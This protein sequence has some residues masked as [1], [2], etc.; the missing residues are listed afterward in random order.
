MTQIKPFLSIVVPVRNEARFIAGTLEQLL[1]QDYPGDRF[2]IL[3]SDGLS[4]DGTVG[5]VREYAR[6]HPQVK[7]LVNEK[8]LSS[9]GR[10]LGFRKGRGDFFLV[11]DGHCHIE[12]KQLFRN[13]VRCFLENKADCLGRPQTLDP[14]GLTTFQKAVAAA[15]ASRLGR[16]G[17]SLIYSDF[18]GYA[19]P[20]SNGAAYGRNVFVKAGYVDE[21]F[22]ACED[23]EF[24]YRVEKAGLVCFSSPSLRVRYFPRENLRGLFRQMTRYGRGR[25]RFLK[26]HPDA[27]APETMI[28]ALFLA[29]MILPLLFGSVLLLFGDA[30][31]FLEAVFGATVLPY[32]LYAMMIIGGSAR[33][34]AATGWRFFPFLPA[35]FLAIH[36]GLGWGFIHGTGEYLQE[37]V[38]GKGT[39][40]SEAKTP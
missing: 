11:V 26:K 5:I 25:F 31:V 34:A 21:N 36:A 24:N 15:R 13:T 12:G 38:F 17:S 8:K 3:V 29:G 2:E 35:I 23:V 30:P 32:I 9:A 10:N 27:F 37:R 1:R 20:V 40:M 28:P 39:R 19:S 6:R 7:L 33:I 16:S 22:D 18:E 14:P 4:E